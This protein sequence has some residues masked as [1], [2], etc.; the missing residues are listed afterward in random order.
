MVYAGFEVFPKRMG[1]AFRNLVQSSWAANLGDGIMLAAGPLLAWSV[2]Q[3]PIVI[4]SVALA[5][6]VPWLVFGLISGAVADRMDRVVLSQLGNVLRAGA[7]LLIGVLV[8]TGMLSVPLMLTILFLYGVAEVFVDSSTQT[9]LPGIVDHSDLAVGNHR[10]RVAFMLCNQLLGPPLGA[11]LFGVHVAIPFAVQCALL[12]GAAILLHG[13]RGAAPSPA[14]APTGVSG[15]LRDVVSGVVWIWSHPG[16]R[17]LAATIFVFNITWGA[18]WSVLVL[19]ANVV[20]GLSAVGFG[21]LTTATAVG[22]IFG[23]IVF[24]ALSRRV[25]LMSLMRICLTLEVLTNLAL[26]LTRNV[27]TAFVVMVVFGAYGFVWAT[28]SSTLRQ[29]AVPKELQGRTG[30]AYALGGFA[31]VVIGQVLGGVIAQAWGP[32]SPFWFAFIGSAA[33]LLAVWR[34]LKHLAPSKD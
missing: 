27:P 3:S 19:W 26:A 2:S 24:P 20:L 12:V 5:Q 4:A 11:L 10:L 16:I 31:G 25:S 17:A 7:V 30:S 13:V 1:S 15:I 33:M 28:V 6:R 23:A 22:G 32:V 29:G 14:D 34:S 18:A 9:I 8:A 21:L